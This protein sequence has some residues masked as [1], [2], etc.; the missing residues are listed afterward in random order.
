MKKNILTKRDNIS[1]STVMYLTNQQSNIKIL[2]IKKIKNLIVYK[3]KDCFSCILYAYY[4]INKKI[5]VS[6]SKAY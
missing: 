3:Y 2:N 5:F 6:Y 1:L 4:D